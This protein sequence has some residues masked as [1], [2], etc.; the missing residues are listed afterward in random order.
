M[1]AKINAE[2]P[3]EQAG[4]RRGRGTSDMLVLLQSII[5]KVAS[6]NSE[7]YIT[8]I[9]YSKAF[10]SVSHVQLFNVMHKMGFPVHIVSLLQS[11]Y[12]DQTAQI[13]WNG[14]HTK[15]FGIGKG[16]R[17]GCVLS[18]H[19]FS[20]YTEAIMREANID[21]KGMTIG[22]TSVS[23]AR[24]ADDTAL[25]ET[26]RVKMQDIVKRVNDAGKPRL[27][28]LNATKTEVMKIGNAIATNEDARIEV[29]GRALKNVSRFKYLGSLK[30][31]N[32]DCSVDLRC[33]IAM[34]K[35]RMRELFPLWKSSIS[36]KLKMKLVKTL[37]WTVL[38]YGAE[39]WTL[40]LADERRIQSAEMWLWRRMLRIS[41]FQKRS[42]VSILEQLNTKRELLAHVRKRKLTYFGH[43]HREGGCQL[44]RT[45]VQGLYP[46]VRRRGRPRTQYLDNVKRWTGLNGKEVTTATRDRN[47]WQGCVRRAQEAA[48]SRT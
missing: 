6:T 17:Q 28:K 40:T 48:N 42:D 26:S 8:F 14:N 47:E 12:Q 19:L 43:L 7:A 33:R 9:D 5:E 37:V 30:T 32:G 24:Y 46:A 29:D 31:T 34:A 10:D 41:W 2:L 25:L 18:P 21:E 3:D 45:V 23:N 38:S 27:L 15:S 13:R 1:E 36:N 22:G 11:L 44:T 4:F 35:Q 39:G 20:L 16:V